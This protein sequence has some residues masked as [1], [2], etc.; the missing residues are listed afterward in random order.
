LATEIT[1]T[2]RLRHGTG[3][4]QIVCLDLLPGRSSLTMKLFRL[5]GSVSASQATGA[6]G[7]S[8]YDTKDNMTA[9]I[10]L[11]PPGVGSPPHRTKIG[12]FLRPAS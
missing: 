3:W 10:P 4:G 11:L 7:P 9:V 2:R 8:R 5:P 12:L 6:T 1:E